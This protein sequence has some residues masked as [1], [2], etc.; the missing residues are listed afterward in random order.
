MTVGFPFD[1]GPPAN[2]QDEL[3]VATSGSH[4]LRRRWLAPRFIGAAFL[5][6][7]AQGP[8]YS[9]CANKGVALRQAQSLP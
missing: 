1:D 9:L 8:R 4:N 3:T 5:T 2:S 6:D 7:H